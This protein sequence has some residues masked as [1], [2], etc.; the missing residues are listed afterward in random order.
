MTN[1]DCVRRYRARHPDR[2]RQSNRA[3]SPA[4]RT[5]AQARWRAKVKDVPEVKEKANALA[6]NSYGPR[7]AKQVL[8]IA[9]TPRPGVCEICGEAGKICLDHCHAKGH[10]RGWLCNRCNLILGH[11]KDDPELLRKLAAYLE[12]TN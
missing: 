4:K 5:A 8:E 10:F 9:G 1:L 6:R 12:R 2:V 3:R 11:A 7:R